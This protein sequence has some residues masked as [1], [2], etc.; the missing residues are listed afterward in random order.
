ALMLIG[1]RAL[2]GLA[3]AALV[4]S[5]LSLLSTLFADETERTR[6]IG[7][8]GASF[9]VGAAIGPLV[10]GVLLEHFWWGAVFLVGV[11]I[12]VLLLIVG[13]T[14]LPEFHDPAAGR[15]DLLSALLSIVSVLAVI[16]G[17]KQIV[18]D[19]LNWQPMLSMLA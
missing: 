13:P 16:Y 4:P 7:V 9:A 10:G 5:T 15:P 11:P 19:G 18:Q 17:L 14:L 3:G 2:L 8:W 12:M 1:A 6:A